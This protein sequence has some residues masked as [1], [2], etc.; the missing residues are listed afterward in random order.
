[1][2]SPVFVETIYAQTEGNPFFMTEVVRLLSDRNELITEASDEPPRI[3]IPQGVREV[4]GQ[5]LNR[6]SEQCNQTLI[7]ASMVGRNFELR[8]L[9]RLMNGWSDEQLLTALDEALQAHLIEESPGLPERYQFSHSLIRDTLGRELSAARRVR[10]HAQIGEALEELYGPSQEAHASELAYHFGA[11]APSTDH[12]KFAHYS[13]IAG[14]Q[15][16]T[17]YAYEDALSHFERGLAARDIT[18]SGTEPAP[19]AEGAALL[20]GLGRALIGTQE[21]QR[22]GTQ[23]LPSGI[24]RAFDYYV[25]A[26]DVDRAVSI[27]TSQNFGGGELIQEALELVPPDSHNAGRL[28]SRYISQGLR[29]D[30]ERAQEA[31]HSALAIARQHQDLGLEMQTLVA[32]ACVDF[33]HCRFEESLDRN[34]RAITLA[35]RVVQPGHESHARHDLVHVL[36]AMGDLEEAAQHA[37]AMLEP[38][39][40]SGARQWQTSA[41]EANENVS[42]AKGDWQAARNFSERGLAM[43]PREANLLGG[44]ALLEYQVGNFDAGGA[45]VERLLENV[46]PS[47]SYMAAFTS[48]TVPAVVIPVVAYITKEMTRFDVVEAIAESVLTSPSAFPAV[49]HAARIGLALIAVQRGDAMAAGELYGTLEPL[50][51]TMSPQGPIGPGLAADRL[52]GLLSQ[53]VGNLDQAVAHFEDALTFCGKAG[54]R[55]ELAWTCHDY[56]DTLLKRGIPGDREKAVSLLDESLA[57]SS[58]LGMRPLMERVADLQERAASQPAKPPAYPD[59]LTQREVEVLQ[60]IAAGRTD[61]EIADELFISVR[62]VGYHVGN[63]LNKTA[64]ANRTEAAAY[65]TRRGLG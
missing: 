39:A 51:G 61:R 32:A 20:S 30:Y 45:H 12:H 26:G 18:L 6:L 5:R 57:I 17:A 16:L 44:R 7:A 60:L 34:R 24:A 56:A 13:L 28:L 25:A 21:R 1:T 27:V 35:A 31:F 59:G 52:L 15:A 48:N 64:V 11:A 49:R 55:P 42:S 65:A 40:R 41:M 4:I 2:P 10:L 58:E 33:T 47:P 14:E 50:R 22:A 37:S 54:Y 23:A 19:D 43:S 46:H 9:S 62:T 38:A 3:S 63:I 36:Y 53:T 29:T 8:L